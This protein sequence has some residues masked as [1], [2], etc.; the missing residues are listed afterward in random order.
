[1]KIKRCALLLLCTC[2]IS[3]SGQNT[4]GTLHNGTVDETVDNTRA[5][6]LDVDTRI[7]YYEQLVGELQ[8]E[9][10][11]VKTELYVNR[12]E[13]ESRIAELEDKSESLQD[14]S[15]DSATDE[16]GQIRSLFEYEIENGGAIIT[17]YK[18]K[19]KAVEIP[20]I[21]DG[22]P[23]CAIADRAFADHV[24]IKS[25]TIPAGVINIGWFAF[26]NCVSLLEI[27]SPSSVEMIGYGAFQNCNAEMVI[28]CTANSYAKQYADSFGIRTKH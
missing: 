11:E 4:N 15:L 27:S 14:P 17:S 3:C 24:E 28:K 5:Q 20:A 21:I 7:S 22:Y 16:G 19:Q 18:G 10:L 6:E 12:I 9:L 1:M 23:V 2:L 13:Y 26:S 25:V 8:Q